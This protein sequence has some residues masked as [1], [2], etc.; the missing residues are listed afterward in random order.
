MADTVG[1]F[2]MSHAPQVMIDPDRW[3][4]INLPRPTEPLAPELLDLPIETKRERWGRCMAAIDQL[5][6][7]LDELAP[8]TVIV[9]GDDQHENINDNNCP[10]FTIFTGKGND[11]GEVE[12]SSSLRY[13]GETPEQNRARYRVDTGLAEWLIDDLME[14]GFDPS[15]SRHTTHPAGLGHAFARL[16]TQLMPQAHPRIV[17]ILATNYLP[18]AD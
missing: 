18:A 9:V 14:A 2:A 15:Y 10:P 4:L 7:R 8:D 5:R 11:N 3:H 13:L 1:W 6:E 16:L 12:A 17:P